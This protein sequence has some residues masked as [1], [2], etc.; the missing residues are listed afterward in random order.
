MSLYLMK[1]RMEQSGMTA[2]DEMISDTILTE[3]IENEHDPSY[4]DTFFLWING[5]EPKDST[6]IHPRLYN[7]KWSSANGHMMNM[8]T[9]ISE[10]IQCGNT[11]HNTKDNTWWVCTETDCIDNINYIS[12]LTECNYCLKWQ[13]NNGDILKYMCIDQNSTQYNSG[14]KESKTNTLTSAQHMITLPL[15]KDTISLPYDKKFFLT[16]DYKN[17]PFVYKLTQNDMTSF[18]GLCKIT[19]SQT[20]KSRNDNTELGICDYIPPPP[21][22]PNNVSQISLIPKIIYKGKPSL[23]LGG[24]FK[25]ISGMFTDCSGSV[26]DTIGIWT[27][28]CDFKDNLIVIINDNQIRIKVSDSYENLAG[29]KFDLIFSDKT[30]VAFDKI[31]F[32]IENYT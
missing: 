31:S 32:T 16:Y 8:K 19:L 12:K 2:R 28:E 5:K 22:S 23:K 6:K 17:S 18:K 1:K 26:I 27:I 21:L 14:I 9:L 30:K 15:V 13:N 24:N 10:P 11:F 3:E 7:R 25:S 29:K 4:C 20:E